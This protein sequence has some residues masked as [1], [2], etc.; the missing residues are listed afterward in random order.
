MSRAVYLIVLLISWMS[1][2]HLQLM[3]SIAPIGL[4]SVSMFAVLI[5][6]KQLIDERKSKQII[7][8]T[9]AILVVHAWNIAIRRPDQSEILIVASFGIVLSG[10]A[11]RVYSKIAQKIH[12]PFHATGLV[13]LALISFVSVGGTTNFG[14][15]SNV[16][17]AII[18]KT[19]VSPSLGTRLNTEVGTNSVWNTLIEFVKSPIYYAINIG[20]SLLDV[21]FHEWPK[22]NQMFPFLSGLAVVVVVVVFFGLVGLRQI[23]FPDWIDV[24]ALSSVIM[25]ATLKGNLDAGTRS[26]L[27]YVFVLVQMVMFVLLKNQLSRNSQKQILNICVFI[28][29]ILLYHAI[30]TW[31]YLRSASMVDFGYFHLSGWTTAV[32]TSGSLILAGTSVAA[33]SLSCLE[34]VASDRLTV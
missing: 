22:G 21:W 24:V 1:Q 13:G 7:I 14:T 11:T 20:H 28:L 2:E 33:L 27:R 5:L 3:G 30:G 25:M 31:L 26:N 16:L 18:P 4:S 29:F 19:L 15:V 9:L 10:L 6:L 12:R 17:R 34:N 8:L 23:S 32:L